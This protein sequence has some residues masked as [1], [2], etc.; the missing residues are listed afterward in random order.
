MNEEQDPKD[1]KKL[2]LK[3]RNISFCK[4]EE[5]MKKFCK[6]KFDIISGTHL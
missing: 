1:E 2:F 6:E 3:K 5:I 4:K